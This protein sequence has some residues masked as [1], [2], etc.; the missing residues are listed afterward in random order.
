M[1]FDWKTLLD[2]AREMAQTASAGAAN[3]EALFRSAVSRA[4]FSAFCYTR[5]YAESYLKYV[6]KQ[7][8]RDHGSLRAHLKG[9]R[10]HADA[11]RL[12]RLRQWRNDADY[13]NDLPWSDVPIV[14]AIAIAES[15]KVFQSL[16]PPATSSGS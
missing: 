9:K 16:S 6:P 13:L 7:D 3:A 8:E 5:N 2:A 14:V 12:E 4:Y 10:R 11:D 15:E 1:S